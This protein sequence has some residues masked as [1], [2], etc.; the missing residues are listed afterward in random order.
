MAHMVPVQFW[1][2][3]LQR[4]R[5]RDPGIFFMAEAYDNDPAKL[6]GGNVLDE[7]LEAGF[8]AV[9]DDPAYDILQGLYDAGKWCNDLDPLTF[10][11]ERFHRS[12]R[13]GEN[14]DEVRLASPKEWGGL[15]MK[16]GRPVCAVL[17][18]LG[19]GPVMLYHG[20]EIG[21][22][23]AGAEGFGGD[24]ARTSIFDY[25]AMPEFQ[26]WFHGGRCD[27]GR[28][29]P[30]QRA[31]RAWYREL[32]G[33]ISQPAFERGGFHGLNHAN[34]DNPDFGRLP[35]ETA[36]GH[37]LYAFLRHD[38]TSV[39]AFLVVANFHGTETLRGVR[40]RIPTE[41]QQWLGRN[42]AAAW[43]ARNRLGPA[44]ETT[45]P[46]AQLAAEGLALPELPPCA[47]LMIELSG[48]R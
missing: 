44:W 12:L 34:R 11:G 1:R 26:K 7:L 47:A 17:F 48:G 18:G 10:S 19:R 43:H 22:P 2:W 27:G 29:S 42:D 13:Y 28:L 9:Y 41:A 24:D 6:T 3:A 39:Q 25:W 40:V 37:W 8:D 14:H 30:E 35:G 20:Q 31:L 33:I 21:E 46:A 36:S 38:R 45:A 23:A 5:Q 16:V 15:G 32:L 4:A